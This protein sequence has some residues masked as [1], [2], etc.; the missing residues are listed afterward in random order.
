M[1]YLPQWKHWQRYE[2]EPNALKIKYIPPIEEAISMVVA[3]LSRK[4][5]RRME[6]QMDCHTS[7]GSAILL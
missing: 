4:I 7:V 3:S 5:R 1:I 2:P 6:L